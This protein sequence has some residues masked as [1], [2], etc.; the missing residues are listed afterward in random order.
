[1]EG[2]DA[3]GGSWGCPRIIAVDVWRRMEGMR[4]DPRERS[5]WVSSLLALAPGSAV[6]AAPPPPPPPLLKKDQ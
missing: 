5:L 4:E 2:D 6:A 1:M 3:G